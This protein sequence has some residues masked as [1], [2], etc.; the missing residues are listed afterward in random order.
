[1][2]VVRMRRSTRGFKVL[3]SGKRVWTDQL[4]EVGKKRR[5]TRAKVKAEKVL[6]E[7]SG[8]EAT[9][10]KDNG[11]CDEGVDLSREKTEMDVDEDATK[12][13]A[14][15][16]EKTQGAVYERKDGMSTGG[17]P[18]SYTFGSSSVQKRRSLRLRKGRI[19]SPLV[20]GNANGALPTDSSLGHDIIPCSPLEPGQQ[21]ISPGVDNSITNVRKSRSSLAGSREN[22]DT[23]TCCA[24]ILVIEVDRCYREEGVVFDLVK[25]DSNQWFVAFEKDGTRRY[26]V[27]VQQ[28]MRPCSF[29]RITHAII[30][31]CDNGWRLEFPNRRDW[32]IFK[33][34]YK[35]CAQHNI[36]VPRVSGIPVPG[37]RE[38]PS[39]SHSS[40][41]SFKRPH[42]YITWKDDELT[43]ALAKGTANYDLDCDDELWLDKFNTEFF[44]DKRINKHVSA[45][46]FEQIINSFE[47]GFYCKQ[48][49]YSDV[50]VA[51]DL[52]MNLEKTEVLEAVHNYWMRKRKQKKSALAR[53]FQCYQS[54]ETHISPAVILGKKRSCNRQATRNGRGQQRTFSPSIG[55][56]LHHPLYC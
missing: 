51:V 5:R 48:D 23:S 11:R 54:R 16:T 3:R 52:S 13:L 31:T 17:Y 40:R 38:V 46:A 42:S 41:G 4:G 8:E 28:V 18:L 21:A 32:L 26:S 1:M 36:Q 49:D 33:E 53:V 10:L 45:D 56:S 35:E 43:R 20:T 12:N 47:K 24:N 6:I 14:K 15:G 19:C 22:I 39:Y 50:R 25:S 30:W 9:L 7:K 37:V 44:H 55:V 2:A 34:L 27:M 29:N